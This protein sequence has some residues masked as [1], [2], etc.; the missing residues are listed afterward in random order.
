MILDGKGTLSYRPNNSIAI[1][2]YRFLTFCIGSSYSFG[3]QKAVAPNSLAIFS[4]VELM[5]TAIISLAPA[6][7]HPIM[8]AKPTQ[9]IPQMA[10]FDPGST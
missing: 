10:H 4:L 5:S 6:S 3:L 8:V 9:P 1:L 7:L 2:C